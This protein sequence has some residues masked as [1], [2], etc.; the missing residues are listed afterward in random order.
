M[1][2]AAKASPALPR[3]EYRTQKVLI[4]GIRLEPIEVIVGE[5]MSGDLADSVEDFFKVLGVL[6]MKDGGK[7]VESADD[8]DESDATA[9]LAGA[10]VDAALSIAARSADISIITLRKADH[11]SLVE[12]VTATINTNRPFFATLPELLGLGKGL[13]AKP[14]APVLPK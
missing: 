11:E 13:L 3:K 12:V 2:K 7:K 10:G 14:G 4:Q 8:F 1:S 5:M 9:L 6:S